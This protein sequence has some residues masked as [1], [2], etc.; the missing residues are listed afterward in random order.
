YTPA[1]TTIHSPVTELGNS[2]AT[3]LFR[4]LE[5]D[6]NGEGIMTYLSPS[7]IVR[8]SCKVLI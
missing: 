4:L 6:E 1:L 3:E 5:A 7:L 8:D 2:S